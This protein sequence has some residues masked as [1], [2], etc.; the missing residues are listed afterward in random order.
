MLV[1]LCC[2]VATTLVTQ[3]LF[4][5]VGLYALVTIYK[6]KRSQSQSQSHGSCDYSNSETYS[7]NHHLSLLD[8][9]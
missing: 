4:G 2:F 9:C 5:N 7:A 1:W 6:Q 3:K 8:N